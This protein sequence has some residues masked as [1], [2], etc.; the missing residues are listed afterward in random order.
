MYE[1]IEGEEK[2]IEDAKDCIEELLSEFEEEKID[3][4]IVKTTREIV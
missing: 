4:I 2:T 1:N 3:Y